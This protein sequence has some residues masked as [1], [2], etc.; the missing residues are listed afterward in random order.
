MRTEFKVIGG[1][2]LGTAIGT[3][4]GLLY[5]PDSGQKTRKKLAKEFK[6]WEKNIED[7]TLKKIEKAKSEINTQVDRYANKGKKAL[8]DLKE[9]VNL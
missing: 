9:Q 8:N 5:A 1:F 6:E 7:S 3:A 2:L 4:V